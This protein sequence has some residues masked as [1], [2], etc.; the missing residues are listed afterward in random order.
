MS[1][2]RRELLLYT[3]FIAEIKTGKMPN[4]IGPTV[5]KM[6]KDIVEK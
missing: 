6:L 5:N 1:L 2:M 4:D 3:L